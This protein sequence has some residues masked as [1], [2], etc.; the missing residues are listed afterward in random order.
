MKRWTMCL[1]LGL[2]LLLLLL[3]ALVL[4]LLLQVWRRLLP[5]MLQ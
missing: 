1:L 5:R 3:L 4:L 2:L